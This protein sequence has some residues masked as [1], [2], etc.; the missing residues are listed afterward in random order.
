MVFEDDSGDDRG[1]EV[2]LRTAQAEDS[3]VAG[4]RVCALVHSSL[5]PL[6]AWAADDG[7][8]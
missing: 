5:K 8:L 4:G 2:V 6:V 7:M 1:D 3:M